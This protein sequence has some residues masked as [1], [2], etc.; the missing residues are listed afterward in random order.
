MDG[1][2]ALADV[3]LISAQLLALQQQLKRAREREFAGYVK[4]A[5]C[6]LEAEQAPRP[7]AKGRG[8]RGAPLTLMSKGVA[9]VTDQLLA[10]RAQPDVAS[11]HDVEPD[12]HAGAGMLLADKYVAQALEEQLRNGQT[13]GKEMTCSAVWGLSTH[14]PNRR[15]L[16]DVVPRLVTYIGDSSSLQVREKAAGALANLADDEEVPLPPSAAAPGPASRRALLRRS[17]CACG[18]R[19]T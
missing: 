1:E 2:A 12:E 14:V 9:A 19:A 4:I 16:A 10:L 17:R 7:S 3:A 11:V 8:A 15:L 5:L 6:F 18:T 13:R